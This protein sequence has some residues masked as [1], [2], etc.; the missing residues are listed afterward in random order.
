D[1]LNVSVANR[2]ISGDTSRALRYRLKEDVLELHPRAV[3]VLIGTND[4]SLGGEPEQINENIK[5]VL[6]ELQKQNPTV[7]IV[8]NRVMPRGPVP[9]KFPEK[10]QKLNTLIDG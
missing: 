9:G 10:I 3:S 6:A 7:P 4:L 1:F 8:L 2:G 5:A